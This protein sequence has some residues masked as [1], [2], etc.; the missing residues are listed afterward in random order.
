[1]KN[2]LTRLLIRENIRAYPLARKQSE[3]NQTIPMKYQRTTTTIG[4]TALALA[5]LL[6]QQSANATLFAYEGFDYA[7]DQTLLGLNGGSGF[8]NAWQTNSTALNNALVVGGSYAYT[9]SFGNSLVTAGNRA[10]VTGNGT[11][12]S[13]TTGAGDNTGGSTANGAPFRALNV[14]RGVTGGPD[15]TW[16]SF[17]GLRT[18]NPDITID[19]APS[20]YLYGRAASAQFFYNSVS[21]ATGTRGNE[22][23]SVGRGTQSSETGATTALPNDTWGVLQQGNALAT[24]ASTVNW[25]SSPADF[26]LMRIDHVGGIGSAGG[27]ITNADTIRIW[28][29][30]L[31]LATA[32]VDG[33]EDILLNAN[34]FNP[35]LAIN[36]DLIF[37][38]L[39][40]F[41]GSENA[42]V[43]YGAMDFD[44]FRIADTFG[45][46]TPYTSAPEP[47]VAA[48]G[49]LSALLLILRRRRS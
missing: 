36:R 48:L 40:L 9:D 30:P 39:G 28:I 49:G 46:V 14:T 10:H 34:D 33:T 32:P 24:K 6:S 22:H 41:G 42:T 47:T 16:I 13:Q 18:G 37:N 1:M 12:V 17:L 3:H 20:D 43:G 4:A 11:A 27:V 26:L 2:P 38:R 29:N 19:P 45:D 8:A 5:A 23:F 21:S 15:T 35:S 25:A 31:S 44:E 7:A